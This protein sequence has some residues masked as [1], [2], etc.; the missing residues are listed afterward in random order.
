MCV[1]VCVCARAQEQNFYGKIF[2]GF[3]MRE[4]HDLAYAA[5]AAF[6]AGPGYLTTIK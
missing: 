5:A 4:A 6:L 2:G 3:L 1:R